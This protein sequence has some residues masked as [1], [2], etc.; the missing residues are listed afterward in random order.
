[1]EVSTLKQRDDAFDIIKGVCIL[2]MVVGHTCLPLVPYRIICSFHMPAF[3][4][5]AGYFAREQSFKRIVPVSLRRLVIPYFIVYAICLISGVL[6][7]D[8]IINAHALQSFLAVK[9]PLK[10]LAMLDDRIL[11]VWFLF[12]LFWCRLVFN[13]I[14]RIKNDVA[15]LILCLAI[16]L[17]A[18]NIYAYGKWPFCLLIGLSA[19]GF[20]STG[21]FL[22]KL[23]FRENKKIW[24]SLPVLLMA[25]LVCLFSPRPLGVWRNV[26]NGFYVVDCLGALA[27]FLILYI[28][29]EKGKSN[30]RM[31]NFLKWCGVNSLIILCVHAI[32]FGFINYPYIKTILTRYFLWYSVYVVILLR[33]LVD[34][35]LAF[36]LT[37]SSFVRRYIFAQE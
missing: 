20:Y 18:V 23:N 15:K 25:W 10:S 37:K 28:V 2:L 11:P 12:A 33:L 35:A 31:W 3:L 4:I 7:Y 1:M 8:G 19:L 14:L 24:E 30:N 16:P 21:F 22:K 26:Y 32:E 17:L 9:T 13:L 6:L 36:L 27:I 34:V 29:V 5:A